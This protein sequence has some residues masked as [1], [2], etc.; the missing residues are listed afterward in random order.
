MLSMQQKITYSF[1]S[2]GL[3][4]RAKDESEEVDFRTARER[5]PRVILITQ[6]YQIEGPHFGWD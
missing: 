6:Y 4:P 3:L 5:E 1:L 2:S